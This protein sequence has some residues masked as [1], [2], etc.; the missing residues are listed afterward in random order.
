MKSSAISLSQSIRRSLVVW[1]AATL[2]ALTSAC[3]H[4]DE[5]IAN[6]EF[7]TGLVLAD[8]G[9][10]AKAPKV[11]RFRDFIGSKVDFSDRFPPA[12][13]QGAQGSCAAW[14]V[15]Y[16]ARSFL[17]GRDVNRA[18]SGPTEIASPSFVF[19]ATKPVPDCRRG[20]S[21]IATLNFVL[22]KGVAPVSEFPI[23]IT[24]C[25]LQPTDAHYEVAARYRIG[26]WKAI[27]RRK[28]APTADGV[29]QQGPLIIDDIKGE[30]WNGR[31]IVFGMFIGKD[32]TT[33]LYGFKG[34]YKSTLLPNKWD[35]TQPRYSHAMT[36]TGFDDERQA[37][38]VLSSWTARWGD[39]G[40][41][42]VDYTTFENLAF[43]AYVVEPPKRSS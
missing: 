33:P 12:G 3:A 2:A 18:P 38:K 42:W 27:E 36:I 28:L 25:A 10:Y 21:I 9:L 16:A 14:A 8:A 23:S 5:A 30:L 34:V 24:E 6:I 13:Y 20:T 22:E 29:E 7:G 40:Y 1:A 26:G 32:F 31:P 15:A 43:E 19:N 39:K 11:E 41:V 17:I 4:A 35:P 37:F